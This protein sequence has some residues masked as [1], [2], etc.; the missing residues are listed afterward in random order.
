VSAAASRSRRVE[1]QRSRAALGGEL[2][3]VIKAEVATLL[4]ATVTRVDPGAGVDGD[5]LCWVVFDPAGTP[6]DVP[7]PDTYTPQV[8]HQVELLIQGGEP[9]VLHRLRGISKP[10][11][12]DELEV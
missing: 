12:D 4:P 3:R 2:A 9:R 11:A 5:D 10:P 6:I 8:G 1:A 7:Y